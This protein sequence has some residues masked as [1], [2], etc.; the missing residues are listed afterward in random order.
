LGRLE[1]L[2]AYQAEEQLD[3]TDSQEISVLHPKYQAVAVESDV[4]GNQELTEE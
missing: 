2:A 1:P 3:S 4:T